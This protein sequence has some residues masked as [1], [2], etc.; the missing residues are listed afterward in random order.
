MVH[1]VKIKSTHQIL[2]RGTV[3]VI[4]LKENGFSPKRS[5]WKA[6]GLVL[7]SFVYTPQHDDHI[8]QIMGIEA[9]AM[10]QEY[11]H[12]SVGLLLKQVPNYNGLP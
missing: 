6:N 11:E 12:G 4:D 8:Y 5:E 3:W 7:G 9:F 10:H 2:G 1:E